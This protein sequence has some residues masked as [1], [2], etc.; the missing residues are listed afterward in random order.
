M[1]RDRAEGGV[2]RELSDTDSVSPAEVKEYAEVLLEIFD[3]DHDGTIS[4]SELSKVLSTERSYLD[5]LK[6]CVQF[7]VS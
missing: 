2:S 6:V 7:R 1:L 4:L 3:R 5:H